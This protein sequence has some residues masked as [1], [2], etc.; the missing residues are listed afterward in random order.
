[1]ANRLFLISVDLD[2]VDPDHST[3]LFFEVWRDQRVRS[4]GVMVSTLIPVIR[5]QISVG[6]FNIFFLMRRRFAFSRRKK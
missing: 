6:L 2:S 3:K 1:M 4:H 5:V